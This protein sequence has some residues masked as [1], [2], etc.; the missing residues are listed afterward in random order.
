MPAYSIEGVTPVVHPTAFVHPDAVL[1]GDVLVGA[2]C[3]VGPLASL[4]GDMGRVEVRA[5]SNI[6]DACVLHCFPGRTVVVEEDGH[7]G[8]AAVLHGCHVGPNA[9]IGIG[10]ILM[11]GVRIGAQAIVGA[12]T[13]VA[14]DQ[15]IPERW[16][17]TGTPAKP[18]RPLTDAEMRWKTHGTG[19][20][21]QLTFR[22]ATMRRVTPL[23]QLE[24]DRPAL[25]VDGTTAEPLRAFR[26]SE[27][28]TSTQ[29]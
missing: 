9:L 19:V 15:V 11:D 10:A 29:N 26:A 25:T 24:A 18:R 13:F 20:Y 27:K 22:S 23:T 17:A 21:Q 5:G 28:G 3:Y 4:R 14:S 7:I 16:L 2:G 6:Q 8:H 12:H 1:I